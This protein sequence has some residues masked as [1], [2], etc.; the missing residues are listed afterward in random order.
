M[1]EPPVWFDMPTTKIVNTKGEKSI[2]VK[3]TQQF[4]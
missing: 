4:I 3:T 2:L 1:K